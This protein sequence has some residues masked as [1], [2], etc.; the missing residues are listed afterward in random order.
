MP[1]N[2]FRP[3][4]RAALDKNGGMKKPNAR[5]MGAAGI[6]QALL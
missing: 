3:R 6:V 1:Q 5:R 4:A 2:T